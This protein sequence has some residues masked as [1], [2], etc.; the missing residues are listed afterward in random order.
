[1]PRLVAGATPDRIVV[2]LPVNTVSPGSAEQST[3][4]WSGLP[5]A[6]AAAP[7]IDRVEVKVI[8]AP[9]HQ[10]R[11][12]ALLASGSPAER[13]RVYFLDCPDLRLRRHGLLVRVRTR[14]DPARGR[15]DVVVKRRTAMPPEI[16]AEKRRWHALTVDLDALPDDVTWSATLKQRRDTDTVRAVLEGAAPVRTLL[17]PEQRAFL[18]TGT[19]DV[20]LIP[21][22][23]D[24]GP[25]GP[26]PVTKLRAG[27]RCRSGGPT[28][29]ECWVLP[30]GSR[31]MEISTP[32]SPA[33]A[34]R[35]AAETERV[36]AEHRICAAE[37]QF[38]K[39][40]AAW[41]TLAGPPDGPASPADDGPTG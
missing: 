34:A 30:D 24:L 20:G 18:H 38:T 9:E 11:V 10:E 15:A 23:D 16:I 22:L 41:A 27:R 39:T 29:L 1:V 19:G 13:R 26:V 17:T 3:A 6:V 35:V 31:I 14:E 37:A 12:L 5:A 28:T 2:I 21:G 36:L 4:P 25:L 32:S 33:R 8:V 7:D 40:D